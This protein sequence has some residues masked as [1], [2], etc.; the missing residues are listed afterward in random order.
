MKIG[1]KVRSTKVRPKEVATIIKSDVKIRKDQAKSKQEV[2]TSYTAQYDD[3]SSL[4]FYGFDINRT[5][6]K[7]ELPEEFTQMSLDQFMNMKTE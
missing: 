1:D 2:R 5:I 7:V 4:I 6:F 3:G